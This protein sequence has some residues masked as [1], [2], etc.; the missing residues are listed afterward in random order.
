MAFKLS[1]IPSLKD[2]VILVT[3]GN[4]GL[5]KESVFQLATRS[6]AKIYLAARNPSKAEAAIAEIKQRAGPECAP[7]QL[8]S[9]DLSS[10]DSVKKAAAEVTANESRLDLLI[11]N[12]GV[13]GAGGVTEDGY[14][15]QFGVNHMGHALLI[16]SLLPLM[17]ETAQREGISAGETRCVIL[18]SSAESFAPASI[19]PFDELKSDYASAGMWA[20]YGISKMANLHYASQ[21]A[22]HY[23]EAKTGIRFVSVHPGGVITNLGDTLNNWPKTE[24]VVRKFAAMLLNLKPVEEEGVRNQLWAATCPDGMGDGLKAPESGGFYYPVGIAGKGSKTAY[25]KAK[26]DELWEWTE[27]ELQPHLAV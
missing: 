7:I 11:A 6:P 22:I 25:N 16:R 20:K 17:Q 9:L 10:L 13:M 15:L 3:G 1:D 12:A 14:E 4:E 19:Y 8:L 23:P 2:K 24:R 27:K 21:L 26:A 18:S 5:G